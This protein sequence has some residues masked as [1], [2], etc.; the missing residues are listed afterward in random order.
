MSYS[1]TVT[2]RDGQPTVE[3]EGEL[4]EGSLTVVGH[5]TRDHVWVEVTQRDA[6]GR[7]VTHAT[8]RSH[9]GA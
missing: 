7:Y 1:V 9:D 3:V 4:P 2:M 6:E 5:R 8:H